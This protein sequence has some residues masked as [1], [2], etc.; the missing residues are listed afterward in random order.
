MTLLNDSERI[1]YGR[2]IVMPWQGIVRSLQ[3]AIAVLQAKAELNRIVRAQCARG[4]PEI[5]NYLRRDIGLP[6]I[7]EV[8]W[9]P[10]KRRR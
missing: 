7:D 4:S 6:E 10:M 1:A 5:P 8:P 3:S 2:G 9:R